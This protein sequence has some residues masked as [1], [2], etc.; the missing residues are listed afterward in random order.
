MLATVRGRRG[1]VMSVAESKDRG[2]SRLVEID[3]MDSAKPSSDRLLWEREPAADLVEPARLPAVDEHPP[4]IA[5]DFRAL[6]RSARWLALS[7]FAGLDG[8]PPGATPIAAPLFGSLQLEDYQ[9]VPLVRSLRMPRVSLALFDDV[10]LGKSVEAGLVLSELI[11]RRRLRR[12]LVLCPAW[13]RHQWR[14]EL[15]SKFSLRFDLVD[16]PETH[17]LRRRLGMDANPWRS[18]QRIIASYHYLKQPDVLADFLSASGSGPHGSATLP[19]DLLVVDE[20]HNCI[21]SA[22]GEDSALAQMLSKVA[23]RFE[24]RI[25][26]TATPH[27]GYT[28]SYT[29]L[30]EQLDPVRFTRKDEL[31]ANERGRVG[32]IVIRRLK[33]EIN[34]ADEDAGKVPRFVERSIV[35]VPIFQAKGEQALS[36]AF[37][38]F[39]KRLRA[40]FAAIGSGQRT[41]AFAIEVL[42]KRLLSCPFAFADSWTRFKDGFEEG[43]AKDDEQATEKEVL[44]A[45]RSAREELDDDAETEGRLAYASRVVGAWLSRVKDDLAPQIAGLDRALT[46]LGLVR[47]G[48]ALADPNEDARFDRLVALV[49]ERFREGKSWKDDE[50]LVVFTE[51]RTTLEYLERRLRAVFP[52]EPAERIRILYGGM[53]DSEREGIKRAF[54]D[55]ADPVRILLAT[56][57][58]SEG[59]NLQRTARFLLHHDIPWNPSRLDQRNGRLDRHGQARDVRVFHYTCE[60]DADLRF[61][62]KVLKK[63]ENVRSDLGSVNQLFDAAFHRRMIEMKGDA[64]VLGELDLAIEKAAAPRRARAKEDIPRTPVSSGEDERRA[65]DWLKAELDLSPDSLREVLEVALG[66]RSAGFAFKGPEGRGRFRFS[67]VPD[68]WRE[69]IDAEVRLRSDARAAASRETGALPAILF[70]SDDQLEIRDGRK[71][72]SPA[73]DAILMHLGHPLA[74]AALLRLSRARFP[75]TEESRSASR[76]IVRRGPLPP[77]TDALLL[78]TVEEMAV[79]DLREAFHHWVRTL[80]FPI[81]HGRLGEPLPHLP[82]LEDLPDDDGGAPP[83]EADV[84]LAREL[85]DDVRRS[86]T[87][88]LARRQSEIDTLVRAEL[89]AREATDRREQE[90]L[91]KE[92]RAGLDKEAKKEQAE[93]EKEL[94][95]HHKEFEG[96]AFFNEPGSEGFNQFD[97]KEKELGAELERRRKHAEEMREYLVAEERRVLDQIL[98]RRYALSDAVRLFPVTLEIRLP[99]GAAR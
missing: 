42:A 39:R 82:A 96:L 41:A 74:K 66:L 94:E 50:R 40:R 13:L 85:W 1:V 98:P 88:A 75:G 81:R 21:P 49:K 18:S 67:A 73:R 44:S 14:E 28:R 38:V 24:H 19:W 33:T 77:D 10:G 8:F 71:I 65:L 31:T 30:L 5:R 84:L 54:N 93:L 55:P 35:P 34:K 23:R 7:P 59:A 58:A 29:G 22:A 6:Q 60:S 80:R 72:H 11:L 43:C 4:M 97:M 16:R 45:E 52:D 12:I 17:S 36:V 68:S 63:V 79:N 2:I 51:Y 32:E 61:L 78:V 95:R 27:N 89:V 3:Y 70:D 86:A 83:P 47:S 9:L 62:G 87:Q 99:G 37:E 26:L 56:D 69:L 25:F 91:F 64:E 15:E 90:A 57:A 46:D 20:A 53:G 48:D 92:R 76:W